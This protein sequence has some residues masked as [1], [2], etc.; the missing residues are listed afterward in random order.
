MGRSRSARRF[1][2][3]GLGLNQF[4]KFPQ[5]REVFRHEFLV[6]DPNIAI[7]FQKCNQANNSERVNLE[8][9]I[10][11]FYRRQGKPVA[12]DVV[13][14]LLWYFHDFSGVM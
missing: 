5:G 14:D 1:H 10:L 3:L 7:G 4:A 9:L 12:I 13:S 2:S 8:W 11:I 6:L